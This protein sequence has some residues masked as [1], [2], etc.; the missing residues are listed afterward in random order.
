MPFSGDV[1]A[2]PA[3]TITSNGVISDAITQH[4][5]PFTDIEASLTIVKQAITS[6]GSAAVFSRTA[7]AAVNPDIQTVVYL[8]EGARSGRFKWTLGDYTA[9]V[10]ADTGQGRFVASSIVAKPVSVGA[11][12]RVIE[13]DF[14]PGF[15]GVGETADDTTALQRYLDA[16]SGTTLADYIPNIN[17]SCN[18]NT[19][20]PVYW[21]PVSGDCINK[22]IR[23]TLKLTALTGSTGT[24]MLTI[25]NNGQLSVG[26]YTAVGIGGVAYSGRAGGYVNALELSNVTRL[27]MEAVTASYFSGY[28]VSQP[29]THSL[30]ENNNFNTIRRIKCFDCGSGQGGDVY[31]GTLQGTYSNIVHTGGASYSQFSTFDA[32]AMPPQS[33]T[34]LSDIL[35]PMYVR[36]GQRFYQITDVD[37]VSS[38]KKISV[39]PKLD[40]NLASTGAYALVFGG[41]FLSQNIDS[42]ISSV[43]VMDCTRVGIGF[44]EAGLYGT[45]NLVLNATICGVGLSIGASGGSAISG[46]CAQIYS[47]VSTADIIVNTRATTTNANYRIDG[48]WSLDLCKIPNIRQ[49]R[50]NDNTIHAIDNTNAI[51]NLSIVYN[52]QEMTV[53][54]ASANIDDLAGAISVNM[55]YTGPQQVYAASTPT[56]TIVPGVL[57]V[58]KVFGR[59]SRRITIMGASGG[60]PTSI[61]VPVPANSTTVVTANATTDQVTPS[62][63]GV[64]LITG[65]RVRFT[66]TGTLPAPLAI[67][68]DYYVIK[69]E[70][71]DTYK[72]A[73]SLAN[74][75]AG[76]AIDLTT[77]GTGTTTLQIPYTLNGGTSS[78]VFNTFTKIPDLILYQQM[79]TN[80]FIAVIA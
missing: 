26:S 56:V 27:N 11:W 4:N 68:T 6:Q 46:G 41:G 19:S 2:L 30:A 16:I 40:F 51:Y 76:T 61:T 59:D 22:D 48:E 23:G 63:F 69:P 29:N 20:G 65:T 5:A 73:T 75:Q 79:L 55:G 14:V 70:G 7:L 52:G 12:V 64:G 1:Y 71:D 3:G 31:T 80:N 25:R 17:W 10:T 28:A 35:P 77:A 45:S 62:G 39:F 67:A 13:G 9:R 37:Y 43:N 21:G 74:A 32:T 72:L 38:P 49:L 44:T 47:E 50:Q 18:A 60:L 78:V 57:G 58:N 15:Y 33:L 66:T 8:S 54:K 24:A 34:T 42:N 36:V 53:E